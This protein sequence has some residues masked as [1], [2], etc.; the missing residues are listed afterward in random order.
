MGT[1]GYGPLDSDDALDWIDNLKAGRVL[2][3][4]IKKAF[5]SR[6]TD[7]DYIRAAAVM[8]S[9][10][11]KIGLLHENQVRELVPYA[12]AALEEL[13]ESTWVHEFDEPAA[14]QKSLRKQI[15]GLVELHEDLPD[16]E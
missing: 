12:I 6:R 2:G 7:Y 1:W 16:V 5:T 11:Y 8:I 10:G 9:R 13:N 4:E 15:E 3:K 14:V